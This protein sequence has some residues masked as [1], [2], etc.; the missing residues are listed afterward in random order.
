MTPS[1][2]RSLRIVQ[3]LES[4]NVGGLE[5]LAVDLAV[6]QKAAGHQPAIYCVFQAG[7]LAPEAEAAGIPVT[8]FHKRIGVSLKTALQ[9]ARQLRRDSV[10]VVHTHNSSIHHYGVLA[11]WFARV[12][13]VVNTRHGLGTLHIHPRQERY[14][15]A[16]MPFTDAVVFVCEDGRRFFVQHRGIPNRKTRV[17][18]NGVPLEKFLAHPAAPGSLSSRIRFGTVG[19]MV[20][21]KAHS[22]LLEA[23]ALLAPRVPHA[24]LCIVGYG[25]LYEKIAAQLH[26]LNLAGR[27]TLQGLSLDTP[28]ILSQ[29]DVFVLSSISEG[30][31]VV[32]LEAMAAGLPLVSTQVGGV[33][34]VAPEGSVAWYC[35]PGAP[36]PLAQAMYQAAVSGDLALRGQTARQIAVARF[37]ISQ[38][39]QNYEALFLELLHRKN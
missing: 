24:E 10:Q 6:A 28:R 32:I 39:W 25:P 8:A 17:I 21:A 3:L 4:L 30:L 7:A 13:V 29:F 36:E 11:A 19:R 27:V 33:P 37:S 23:F 18:L 15:R 5:R 26:R 20:P 2:T 31:P 14:F 12:P 22:I 16:M 9:I 35:S 34:E 38:M 1:L